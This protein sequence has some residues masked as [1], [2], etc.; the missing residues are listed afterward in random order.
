MGELEKKFFG[1]TLVS[2]ELIDH[3]M[4]FFETTLS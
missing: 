3:R 4:E 1:T 2:F